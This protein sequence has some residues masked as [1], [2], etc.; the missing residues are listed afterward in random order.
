MLNPAF[1]TKLLAQFLE[2]MVVKADVLMKI[3][4]A[5]VDKTI[6]ISEYVGRWTL[7]VIC[8]KLISII[9]KFIRR[10]SIDKAVKQKL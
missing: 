9:Y 2:T 8:G 6:D 7:D 4:D 1:H 10:C 3:L 5:E